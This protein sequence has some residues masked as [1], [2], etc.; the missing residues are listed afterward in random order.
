MSY[1][2]MFL[3]NILVRGVWEHALQKILKYVLIGAFWGH[4]ALNLSVSYNR[5]NVKKIMISF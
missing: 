3:F 1:C 5:K 4:L 2:K